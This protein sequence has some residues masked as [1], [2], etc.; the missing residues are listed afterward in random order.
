MPRRAHGPT[1][2]EVLREGVAD[3][4]GQ[5][6]GD[7]T[8]PLRR[9]KR[10]AALAPV[11]IVQAEARELP[12]PHPIRHQHHEDRKGAAPSFRGSVGAEQQSGQVCPVRPAREAIEGE[13]GD[14][15]DRAGH[16]LAQIAET[17][18]IAQQAAQRQHQ[19]LA[20]HPGESRGLSLQILMHARR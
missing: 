19:V 9:G 15:R 7:R 20:G 14:A 2:T 4:R 11:D 12:S 10:E 6:H 3:R 13:G 5:G 17:E 8:A 1:V 16:V 18:G